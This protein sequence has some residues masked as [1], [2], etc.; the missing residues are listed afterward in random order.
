MKPAPVKQ[1]AMIMGATDRPRYERKRAG[2]GLPLRVT[3]LL[4]A[5]HV[6]C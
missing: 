2:G 6:S 1:F 3:A 5:I 4:V